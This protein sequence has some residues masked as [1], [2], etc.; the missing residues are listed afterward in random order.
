MKKS[1][2]FLII[3]G[4]IAVVG[5]AIFFS[6]QRS[7][8]DTVEVEAEALELRD[9]SAVVEASGQIEPAVSVDI[10]SDVIGRIVALGAEEGDRVTAGQFL[11]QIDPT[12]FEQ[13]L[14]QLD[15]A[16]DT[17][18]SSL[19]EAE[20]TPSASLVAERLSIR[21]AVLSTRIGWLLRAPSSSC[22]LSTRTSWWPPAGMKPPR[23]RCARRRPRWP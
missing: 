22:V 23:R 8:R 2:K 1:L 16:L 14:A 20:A 13:R 6:R 18:R 4:V 3:F 10:S 19:R 9:L 12:Q 11:I 5:A 7:T 21:G 17:A 15:A